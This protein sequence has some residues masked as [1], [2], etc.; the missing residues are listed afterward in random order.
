MA[1]RLQDKQVDEPKYIT[2]S[3]YGKYIQQACAYLHIQPSITASHWSPP[4]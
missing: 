2:S 1:E 3:C 4:Y